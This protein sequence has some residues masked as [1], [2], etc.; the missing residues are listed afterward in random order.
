MI[1]IQGFMPPVINKRLNGCIV[2]SLQQHT[3]S[4]QAYNWN[5]KHT[6]LQNVLIDK[7]RISN[8]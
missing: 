8:H 1:Y 4:E 7:H 5:L 6:L 3:Y 2:M